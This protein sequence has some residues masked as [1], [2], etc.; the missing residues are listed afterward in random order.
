LRTTW[1][2]G[3]TAIVSNARSSEP[4]QHP[5]GVGAELDAG[6]DLAKLRGLLVDGDVE[7]ALAQRDGGGQAAKSASHDCDSPNLR[8][9]PPSRQ[10]CVC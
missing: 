3:S 2:F 4:D 5:H 7:A 10:R 8:H 6:A 1:R 9:H